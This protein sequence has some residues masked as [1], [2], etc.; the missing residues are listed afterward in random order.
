M[1]STS[2]GS[3]R[4]DVPNSNKFESGSS[5]SWGV[6]P[7]G[8]SIPQVE[9]ADLTQAETSPTDGREAESVFQQSS[10]SLQTLSERPSS[11]AFAGFRGF[12]PPKTL[13]ITSEPW[14][15]PYGND[16][17]RTYRARINMRAHWAPHHTY[18]VY[19]HRHR[20]Y[21]CPLCGYTPFQSKSR[22]NEELRCH[23]MS[24]SA[25]YSGLWRFHPEARVMHDGHGPEVCETCRDR[26]GVRDQNVSLANH[27][28]RIRG[29]LTKGLTPFKS[30]CAILVL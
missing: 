2:L 15:L 1:N 8:E 19:Y 23:E 11:I 25:S 28:R 7:V 17:V 26:A 21:V 30:P 14:R 13:K 10:S 27:V 20:I 22:R 3:W 24:G 18:L 6:S 4:S 16:P 5:C 12:S 9:A 29:I